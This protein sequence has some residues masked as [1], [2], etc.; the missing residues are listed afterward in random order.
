[1]KELFVPEQK[2]GK[3]FDVNACVELDNH[4][5]ALAFFEKVK[6]RLLNVNYW[7]ELCEFPATTFT[8]ISGDNKKIN[9]LAKEKDYIRINIPGPGTRAGEGFDWV[10]VERVAEKSSP[11]FEIL[12][13]TVR[14]VAHP[15]KPQHGVAHFFSKYSTSTFQVIRTGNK[16]CAAV[17]GRNEMSNKEGALL[18]KFRNTL[19]SFGAKLGFS[20]PQWKLLVEGLVG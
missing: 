3:Q 6:Q 17:H 1:M 9:R 16:I 5:D 13:M 4:A 20:Y 7:Y 19:I 12:S 2:E 8:L 18:D 15:L 11:G 14:P 10:Q